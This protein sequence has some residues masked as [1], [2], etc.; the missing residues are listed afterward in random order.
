MDSGKIVLLL[1]KNLRP[2]KSIDLNTYTH[3][4]L[5]TKAS[6]YLKNNQVQKV[7]Q[8]QLTGKNHGPSQDAFDGSDLLFACLDLVRM[9]INKCSREVCF[10]ITIWFSN[11]EV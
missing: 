8:A 9:S 6:A 4:F 7:G 10:D 3:T 11:K 1:Q 2:L 5:H